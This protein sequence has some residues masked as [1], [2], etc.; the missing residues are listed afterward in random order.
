MTSFTTCWMGSF[1]HISIGAQTESKK[2]NKM[3]QLFDMKILLK[4][5]VNNV[6]YTHK[7]CCQTLFSEQKRWLVVGPL[8]GV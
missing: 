6:F 3:T 7:Y 5:L 4:L 1:P 2:Y 8:T